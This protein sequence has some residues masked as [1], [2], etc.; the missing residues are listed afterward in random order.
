MGMC[1]T[2]TQNQGFVLWHLL[3][4][5]ALRAKYINYWTLVQDFGPRFGAGHLLCI[6]LLRNT[7][8]YQ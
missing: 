7:S 4:A 2:L 1:K 8:R 3:G 6:G 5:G